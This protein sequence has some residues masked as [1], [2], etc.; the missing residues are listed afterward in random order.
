MICP[1]CNKEIADD[2]VFCSGCGH[3]LSQEVDVTATEK[4]KK[5]INVK[6]V[7]GGGAAL[8]VL[9]CIGIFAYINST[10]ESKYN[11]AE[12]AFNAGNYAQAIKYYSAAGNYGDAEEKLAVAKLANHYATGLSLMDSG[13]YNEAKS[14]LEA[15][16]DYEDA[17]EKIQECDYNIA[18]NFLAEND[19]L[20]AAES[21]KASGDYSDADGQIIQIGQQLVNDG[22]YTDAVTVFGYS[23][24]WKSNSYAQYANGQVALSNKNYSGAASC[25]DKAGDILDAEDL[26]NE[27]QYNYA[28]N[29]LTS[30]KYSSAE[31]AFRK[32]LGYKDSADLVNACALMLAKEDMDA[33]KLNTAKTALEKLPSDFSYKDVSA[34]ELLEQLDS[35]SS[36][37]AICGKWSNTSGEATTNCRARNYS[38]DGGTWTI[39][40]Y[41]GDYTLDIK[42]VLNND[43]TVSVIGTGTI[44]VFTNWSTIQIGLDYNHSYSVNFNKKLSAS[45]IGTSISIDDYTTITLETDKITL[46]YNYED[47][48][49]TVGFIY[50]YETNVTYGKST[51]TY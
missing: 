29:Q 4:A 8:I 33:G 16:S 31:I 47:S 11:K 42:C 21:F 51:T 43:G 49:S 18:L 45:D 39:T 32:I 40:F 20:N 1:K 35:N 7:I 36:W 19:Y 6:A 13:S 2:S 14:E 48:N 24:N 34:A 9:V 41:S 37:L 27:A 15:S 50:I 23:K 5:K 17:A 26:Y 44:T 12:K 46:N 10:P 25:F 3:K 28:S 22:N 38:Y 30:K